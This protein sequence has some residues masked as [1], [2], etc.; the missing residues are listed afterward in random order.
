MRDPRL[1]KSSFTLLLLGRLDLHTQG[2]LR[3]QARV[4]QIFVIVEHVDA[5]L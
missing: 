3:G 2:I 4:E 1:G 5:H